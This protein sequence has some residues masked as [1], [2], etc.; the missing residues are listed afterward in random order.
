MNYVI[1]KMLIP[2]QMIFSEY[3]E[4]ER[5]Q[6][7]LKANFVIESLFFILTNVLLFLFTGVLYYRTSLDNECS[8]YL[9]YLYVILMIGSLCLFLISIFLIKNSRFSLNKEKKYKKITMTLNF[10]FYFLCYIYAFVCLIRNVRIIQCIP[11]K[12]FLSCLIMSG[13][14]FYGSALCFFII[15]V[16][17]HFSSRDYI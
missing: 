14:T 11:F 16:Y 1:I 2:D 8:D 3:D 5:S 15:E 9:N 12:I 13:T 6:Y 4:F 10:V 7:I 17:F